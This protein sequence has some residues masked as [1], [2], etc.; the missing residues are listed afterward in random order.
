MSFRAAWSVAAAKPETPRLTVDRP[1]PKETYNAAPCSRLTTTDR[2]VENSEAGALPSDASNEQHLADEAP[3]AYHIVG[4]HYVSLYFEDLAPAVAFYT[5]VFGPPESVEPDGTLHGWRMGGTWL[6]FFPARAGT[7][8]GSNPRNTEFAI[9]LATPGEVDRLYEA[10]IA[11]G[12]TVCRA[13][14]DTWMYEPMRYCCV[15]DPFGVRI[16]VYCP[17]GR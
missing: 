9:Q 12:A 13:P 17:S 1:K 16:D 7:H 15:D 6:S 3:L 2:R 4:L 11:A 10:L 5:Q 8:P 14:S